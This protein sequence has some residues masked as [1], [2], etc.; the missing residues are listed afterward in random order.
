MLDRMS[1]T[2]AERVRVRGTVQGVGF[3]PYVFRLARQYG[4]YGWVR[5]DVNG[6]VA[7]V[8]GSSGDIEAFGRALPAHQP[9]A[10]HIESVSR[11]PAAAEGVVGFEIVDSDLA[12]RRTTRISPD[13]PV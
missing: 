4:L 1:E 11:E 8:E 6:V 10:A 3:R 12:G 7:H 2:A 9:P 5:N 13:L